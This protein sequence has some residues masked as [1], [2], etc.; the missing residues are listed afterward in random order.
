MDV[1]GEGVDESPI[2]FTVAI[3]VWKREVLL[4]H[5]IQS[6]TRQERPCDE[7]LV[8][9]DGRS[10]EAEQIVADL[11]DHFPFP[12]RYEAVR[13]RRKLHG[14]HLRRHALEAA[15]GTH[16]VILGHDC[17]LYGGYLAA[18][19]ATLAGDPD[20]LSVVR[21]DYWRSTW[22]DGQMPRHDDLM[23][24]GEGKI[25]LLCLAIPRRLA[26]EEDCFGDDMLKIRCAD[27]LT[28]DRLRHRTTPLFHGGEAVAAHF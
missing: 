21:V 16:V 1:V 20:G 12:I 24:V 4:P 26:L 25:D 28:Y 3:T 10:K 6:V 11:E 27:Y 2:R 17:L 8:L 14:N 19:D 23:E 5:A 18:H 13:R 15:T 9:S 22:P 7:I